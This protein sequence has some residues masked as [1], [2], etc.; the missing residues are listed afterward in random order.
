[1][2]ALPSTAASPG[3]NYTVYMLGAAVA[4]VAAG[5]GVAGWRKRHT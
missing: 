5:A 2:T 3:R 1:V 4:F